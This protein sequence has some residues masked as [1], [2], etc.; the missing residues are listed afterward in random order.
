MGSR[1][2]V[3]LCRDDSVAR[4]RFGDEEP[5]LGVVATRTGRP[6]FPRRELETELLQRLSAAASRAGLWDTLASDWMLLDVEIVPWSQKALELLRTQYAAVGTAS[7]AALRHAEALAARAAERIPEVGALQHSLGERRALAEKFTE[8]YRRYCW[9]VD[10]LRGVRVCPFH[11]LASEGK[12][13]A[14]QSNLWHLQMADALAAAD[15][16]LILRTARQVVETGNEESVQ[17]GIAF[18]EQLTGRGGEGMVVKSASF[19][20]TGKKGLAQPALKVRGP[21]YL[22]IIYG[23]E[24]TLPQH[25]SRLR[26][27]SV[28]R[29]RSLALRELA[30]GLEG[31]ERFV[32]GEPLRRVHECVFGVLALESEPVDPRLLPATSRRGTGQPAARGR[33]GESAAS[34]GPA[35]AGWQAPASDVC[36]IPRPSR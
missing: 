1:A 32:A 17:A 29:K 16:E 11:L 34:G 12:V 24:Y 25:L 3:V 30:L 21:E 26:T 27:R 19:V 7:R 2:V 35:W 20:T 10:G 4:T 31:L 9:D 14:D 8:A 22:R 33:C 36:R 5:K 28:G 15:E 18:W 13:H 6:F 23:P